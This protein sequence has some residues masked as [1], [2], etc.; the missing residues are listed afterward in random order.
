VDS[1]TTE[2]SVYSQKSYLRKEEKSQKQ[3]KLTPKG[4]RKRRTYKTQTWYKA[5]KS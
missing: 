3:P 1:L 4:T 2:L 5:K